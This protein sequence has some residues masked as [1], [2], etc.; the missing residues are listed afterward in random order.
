[1]FVTQGADYIR[2]G[3]AMLVALPLH[4]AWLVVMDEP[5]RP[6]LPAATT[7]LSLSMVSLPQSLPVK[8]LLPQREKKVADSIAIPEAVK[9]K[10]ALQKPMLDSVIEMA[11][12]SEPVLME[13]SI[14]EENKWV[15]E[16]L[17]IEERVAVE[18][19]SVLEAAHEPVAEAPRTG[20]EMEVPVSLAPR[21][22]QAPAPPHYP[23]QA[24]RRN[25]Q[26]TVLLQALVSAGGDTRDIRIVKSSGYSLLDRAAAQAVKKWQFFPASYRGSLSSAWVQVPVR[27]A[28]N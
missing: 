27:F 16:P 8:P 17:A 22:R 26:G 11:S 4:G 3:V 14:V 28:L 23:R 24:K 1:M 20:V 2:M 7:T 13:Q 5:V 15:E 18:Q 25:Q 9:P 12:L 19:P 21:F 6:T 10:K